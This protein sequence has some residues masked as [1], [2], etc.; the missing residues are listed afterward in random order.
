MKITPF[1]LVETHLP[2]PKVMAPGS[3][4]FALLPLLSQ[5]APVEQKDTTDTC[6]PYRRIKLYQVVNA[7]I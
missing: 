1:F 2:S 4:D 3:L 5:A 7:P 6:R